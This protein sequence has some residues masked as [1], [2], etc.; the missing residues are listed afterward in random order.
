MAY[1]VRQLTDLECLSPNKHLE[2]STENRGKEAWGCCNVISR[3]EKSQSA[4]M[5]YISLYTYL[6][7]L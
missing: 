2:N 6:H 5:T 7:N 3:G 1:C 4:L